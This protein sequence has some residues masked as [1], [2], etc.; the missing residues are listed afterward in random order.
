MGDTLKKLTFTGPPVIGGWTFPYP[1]KEVPLE[2]TYVPNHIVK[3]FDDGTTRIVKRRFTAYFR[4][5]WRSLSQT[6]MEQLI[7]A[8]EKHSV[9]FMPRSQAPL[10]ANPLG[11]TEP[12]QYTVRFVGDI[13]FDTPNRPSH[14][15]YDV[16][17]ELEVITP[18]LGL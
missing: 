13:P 18:A 5:G 2:P 16:Q 1:A 12:Y 14:E 3:H 9:S 17:I 6:D 4:L 10:D 7:E 15:T 8:A 11:E